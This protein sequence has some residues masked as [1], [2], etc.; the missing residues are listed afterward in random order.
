MALDTIVALGLFMGGIYYYSRELKDRDP[1]LA[2]LF[3]AVGFCMGWAI[4]ITSGASDSI[5]LTGIV[6]TGIPFAFQFYLLIIKMTM[7]ELMRMRNKNK[8]RNW[9][10]LD[11]KS[12]Y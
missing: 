12:A 2:F 7:N 11:E 3:D 10:D 1:V 5:I 4:L 8:K 6:L 9:S